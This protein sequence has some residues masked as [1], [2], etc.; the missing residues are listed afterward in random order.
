M[1]VWTLKQKGYFATLL[2]LLMAFSSVHSD[3]NLCRPEQKYLDNVVFSSIN[4]ISQQRLQM[5]FFDMK[6]LSQK[7]LNKFQLADIRSAKSKNEILV[8]NTIT[9]TVQSL[10]ALS[11][12]NNRNFAVISDSLDASSLSQ[13]CDSQAARSGRI[14][15]I[16]YGLRGVLAANLGLQYLKNYG[17]NINEL[18]HLLEYVLPADNLKLTLLTQQRKLKTPEYLSVNTVN[19][20]KA[21]QVLDRYA[22]ENNSLIIFSRQ[23][24]P[25]LAL[26]H[27]FKM[28]PALY[29]FDGSPEHAI[30]RIIDNRKKRIQR[31]KIS[32]LHECG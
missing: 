3:E 8:P 16:P 1:L 12:S 32:A 2:I 5:C 6:K 30:Q 31:P 10:L 28:I 9:I 23:E 29:A 13:L 14:K 22:E 20:N 25:K 15:V 18:A 27:Q 17:G 11:Q 24:F 19:A 26:D 21:Q 7:T 4:A